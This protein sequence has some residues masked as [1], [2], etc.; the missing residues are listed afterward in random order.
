MV[1]P[2][3]W[4]TRD[5]FTSDRCL[6]G[7]A[8]ALLMLPM[9]VV[10]PAGF[11]PAPGAT[12]AKFR[13]VLVRARPTRRFVR[14]ACRGPDPSV[15]GSR[16]GPARRAGGPPPRGGGLLARPTTAALSRGSH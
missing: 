10:P 15:L 5:A 4:V 1:A 13:R 2:N 8:D 16:P 3:G 11:D 6:R 7:P 9:F 14:R 12:R